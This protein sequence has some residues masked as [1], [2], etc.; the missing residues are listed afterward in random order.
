[1]QEEQEVQ[2]SSGGTAQGLMAEKQGG[3]FAEAG[4][5]KG[6]M[7]Q[8]A[9]GLYRWHRE[10]PTTVDFVTRSGKRMDGAAHR[11]HNPDSASTGPTLAL[12]RRAG[13]SILSGGY[14]IH[15]RGIRH[16]TPFFN[17]YKK[18]YQLSIEKWESDY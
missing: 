12:W 15:V 6:E 9:G 7:G 16:P 4:P 18:V 2:R 11:S 10:L 1:M 14:C 3:L 8:S 5:A 13:K 17:T